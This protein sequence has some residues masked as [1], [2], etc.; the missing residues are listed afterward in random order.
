MAFVDGLP[1]RQMGLVLKILANR[2]AGRQALLRAASAI[3]GVHLQ[4]P[5]AGGTSAAKVE[6][7]ALEAASGG[8][9][10]SPEVAERLNQT[11]QNVSEMLKRQRILGVRFGRSWRF[12]AVQFR[13]REVLPGLP[14]VIQGMGGLDQWQKLEVLL[15]LDKPEERRP[16]QLLL[17]GDRTQA[18]TVASRAAAE[19]ARASG[20][21][22]RR[23]SGSSSLDKDLDA[24]LRRDRDYDAIEPFAAKS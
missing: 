3:V 2:K 12:P 21:P 15:S 4:E 18:L 17:A 7:A 16:L 24:D 5:E 23:T 22:I 11:R 9:L 13:Q 1:E 8:M 19:L 10:T 6:T 14:A 20:L